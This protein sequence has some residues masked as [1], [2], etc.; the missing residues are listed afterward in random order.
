MGHLR[1]DEK[2][3]AF[4]KLQA[5]E[6]E[7]DAFKEWWNMRR[8]ELGEIM[9]YTDAVRSQ[10]LTYNNLGVYHKS[11]NKHTQAIKYLKRVLALEREIFAV[12]STELCQT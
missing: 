2:V 3:S 4:R 8:E 1:K 9:K 10:T 11:L 12:D 6:S 5:A 7:I